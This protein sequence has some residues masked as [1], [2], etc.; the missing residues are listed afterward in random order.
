[1]RAVSRAARLAAA[2]V[3]ALLLMVVL[4]GLIP[5][6]A[7]WVEPADGVTIGIDATVAHTELILP[8]VA[9][10][11]D[12]GRALPP[13]VVTPGVTHLSFSWGDAAFFQATP[14]WA[15]FRLDRALAA[16]FASR[17]SLVHVY[18]LGG[19]HGR[20][21]RLRPQ[22][23]RRLAGAIAAEI[24]AGAAMPGYGP[25]DL[26]LPSPSHYSILRTCNNWAG[27]MLAAAGV[28]VGLW[29]PLSQTLIWRF[30]DQP[31]A[32]GARGEGT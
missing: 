4:G 12:W 26:F 3:V 9:A 32:A 22:D 24:G 31:P 8:V 10:G 16:L 2:L 25:D 17:G 20:A 29:T 5:R 13:G 6:N 21:I 30:R 7:G 15:E 28:R 19:A 14:T 11:H 1:M 27:D 23:Y 18:R